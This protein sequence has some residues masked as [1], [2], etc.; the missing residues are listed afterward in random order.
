MILKAEA[1]LLR[2]RGHFLLTTESQAIE[3]NQAF[4]DVWD[5]ASNG[6]F[7]QESLTDDLVNCYGLTRDEASDAIH[8]ILKV[9]KEYDLLNFS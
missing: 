2:F 1:R 8:E 9:W 6:P 4:G 7:T 3:V 5:F